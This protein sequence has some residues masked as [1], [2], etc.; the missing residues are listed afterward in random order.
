MSAAYVIV[1]LPLLGFAA[2][3]VFGKR[4]GDPAAGWL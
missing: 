1:L 4:L 2:L 3:C